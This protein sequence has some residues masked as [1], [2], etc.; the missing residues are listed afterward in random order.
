MIERWKI[1]GWGELTMARRSM[2]GLPR[3]AAAHATAPPQSCPTSAK[4]STPERIGEREDIGDQRVGGVSRDVLRSV[5]VAKAA[6]VGHDQPEAVAEQWRDLGP[7]AV[8]FG[9]AV[10]QDDRRGVGGAGNGDVH[11]DAGREANA[12]VRS[13]VAD[14]LGHV[15]DGDELFLVAGHEREIAR[16]PVVLGLGQCGR[17][18]S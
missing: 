2:R 9:K 8:R 15:G 17:A 1:A 16:L 12:A 11:R 6:Q 18:T 13:R 3:N 14:R 5:A 7:G 10:E 4:R